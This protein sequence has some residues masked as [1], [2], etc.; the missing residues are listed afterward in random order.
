MRPTDEE[1]RELAAEGS[2]PHV[3]AIAEECLEARERGL[4][5][6]VDLATQLSA[7]K[8]PVDM[9]DGTFVALPS[10]GLSVCAWTPE[11]GGR[12]R[13]TQVHLAMN[14]RELDES[15]GDVTLVH[16][17]KS[18]PGVDQLIRLL[19]EYRNEV[20]PNYRGVRVKDA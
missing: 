2:Q 9:K 5:P 16:R 19:A 17:M 18:G 14:L 13:A 7:S 6:S 11:E 4:M 15:L 10:G 3:K 1:L 20:W 8:V 12:G